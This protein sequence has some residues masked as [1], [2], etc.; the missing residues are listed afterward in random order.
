MRSGKID[1]LDR[2]ESGGQAKVSVQVKSEDELLMLQAQAMSLGICAKIIHDAGR[3][4][5]ASG[6]ATVLGV[7]PGPKSMVDQV[8]GSLKL[9]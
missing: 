1:I 4:Q 2:W 7:G 9:L 3:T 8:T 6:S 5:I